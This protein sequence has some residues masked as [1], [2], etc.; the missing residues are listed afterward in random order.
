MLIQLANL[1]LL[2][3]SKHRLGFRRINTRAREIYSIKSIFLK[4]HVFAKEDIHYGIP[5]DG[6]SVLHKLVTRYCG[7]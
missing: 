5:I 3:V 1:M 6:V 2:G 4:Y 7:H